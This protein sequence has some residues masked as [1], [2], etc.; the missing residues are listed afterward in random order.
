MKNVAMIPARLGSKRVHDK[1]LRLIGGKPL[2]A[3]I[4]EAVIESGVFALDDI[5]LNSESDIIK[6]IADDYGIKFYIRPS[7]FSTDTASNDD[8][9]LD[10]INKVDKKNK[11]IHVSTP[12]GLIEL[13]LQ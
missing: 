5:Y 11:E 1:N 9:V 13:Y 6:N 4:V 3:Y 7:E 8:W 2:V 10:F 12:E